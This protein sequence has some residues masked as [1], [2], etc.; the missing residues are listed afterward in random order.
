M[1]PSNEF[2]S[3]FLKP[4][5][6]LEECRNHLCSEGER[7]SDEEIKEI[8]ALILTFVE[9]DFYHFHKAQVT[10]IK[11][12]RVVDFKQGKEEDNSYRKAG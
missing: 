12:E 2:D 6:S 4:D 11:G 7:Y 8:R 5:L 3:H 9:I 1:E 10:R